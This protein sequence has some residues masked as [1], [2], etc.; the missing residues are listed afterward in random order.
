MLSFNIGIIISCQIL[1]HINEIIFSGIWNI[2]YAYLI[3]M[4]S[5]KLRLL[6]LN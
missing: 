6:N 2:L 4:L 1:E 5:I 3:L